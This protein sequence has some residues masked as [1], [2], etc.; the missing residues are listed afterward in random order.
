MIQ[1]IGCLDFEANCNKEAN[2]FPQDIIEV[3]IVVVRVSDGAILDNSF[4]SYVA[5]TIPLTVFCTALT[6]ITSEMVHGQP[7]LR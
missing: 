5:P 2:L 4:H 1:F 3:P 6:G 7:S